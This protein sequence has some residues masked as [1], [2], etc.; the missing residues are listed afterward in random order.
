MKSSNNR[1]QQGFSLIELLIT[2]IIL[3]ILATVAIIY[4]PAVM[5]SSRDKLARNR[6]ATVADAQSRFKGGMGRGRFG[7]VCELTKIPTEDG[8]V[9]LPSSVAKFDEACKPVAIDNW[10]V[11]DNIGA[12][13][14][15][16]NAALR[17]TY[18]IHLRSELSKDL[19]FCMGP[20]GILRQP[21]SVRGNGGIEADNGNGNGGGGAQCT[22]NSPEVKQ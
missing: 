17:K 22:L 12:G 8:S 3:A 13:D 4:G 9:L 21:K 5:K 15:A 16:E 14:P 18:M 10:Y 2:I 20:D 6:L 7:S 1:K 11:E 19:K